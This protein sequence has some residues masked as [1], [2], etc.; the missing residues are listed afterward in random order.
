LKKWQ[1]ILETVQYK[2]WDRWCKITWSPIIVGFLGGLLFSV[3]LVWLNGRIIPGVRV[4]GTMVGGL[5]NEE[6]QARLVK[7]LSAGLSQKLTLNYQRRTFD[8]ILGTVGIQP[9]SRQTVRQAYAVGR[10]GP[11]WRRLLMVVR[12][13]RSGIDIPVRFFHNQMVLMA[14]YRLLDASI[15]R[16]PVRAVVR[17]DSGGRVTYNPSVTGRLINRRKLTR[18]FE[19][20]VV[21]PE[22]EKID[23]PVD[24]VIPTLTSADIKRWSFNRVLGIY[25]TTFNPAAAK[26]THNLKTA[27]EALNNVIVYPGQ[28]FSFNTWIGPRMTGTG[29]KEAPV[30]FKG[31]LVPGIGGGVCQVSS[32]LYNAVLLAN[33]PIVKRYNHSLPS[34]YVPL[35]RDA[36]VVDGGMDFM[37]RNSLATPILLTAEVVPPYVRVAVLG[38]KNGWEQVELETEIVARYP[39]MKRDVADPQLPCGK[40][41]TQPGKL[42]YKINLWRTVHYQDGSRR[43]TLVNTSIYP[44]QP[45]ESRVGTKNAINNCN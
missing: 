40:V 2:W 27:A 38:E 25:R 14:F 16:E 35:G 43:K 19:A 41:V 34:A 30:V 7:R 13:C 1:T 44:A 23:I 15:G 37:F 12:A 6:A 5:T 45:E 18:R 33:L 8:V 11:F 36:T 20:A 22:S 21:R 42:G 10:S 32:T 4:A 29:Y 24:E 17:V 31:K 39:F 9:D 28:N 26:R 3:S